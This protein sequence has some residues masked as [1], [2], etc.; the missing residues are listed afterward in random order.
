[1]WAAFVVVYL[2]DF[3]CVSKLKTLQIFFFL[4]TLAWLTMH[5]I[6][7]QKVKIVPLIIF[8]LLYANFMQ[9]WKNILLTSIMTPLFNKFGAIIT[10][11]LTD[12]YHFD[13]IMAYDK[14]TPT[15]LG[16]IRMGVG[17]CIYILKVLKT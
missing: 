11:I 1:M 2:Y 3:F 16:P 15:I 5:A 7:T 13:F 8:S 14:S 9:L 6:Y 12:W 4:P 10:W 17:I